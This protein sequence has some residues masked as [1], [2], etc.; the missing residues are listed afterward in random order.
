MLTLSAYGNLGRDPEQKEINGNT[1]TN[2][3]IA[4]NTGRDETTWI[5]CT[6]FGKRGDVVMQYFKKGGKVAVSGS[7]KLREYTDKN[8]VIAKSL[9][10][11]VTD[12]SLP[13]RDTAPA[14]VGNEIDF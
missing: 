5:N 3:S 12:F 10:L 6:V 11:I 7:A 14:A 13:A 4:A 2:F 9:D 1:I 8:G